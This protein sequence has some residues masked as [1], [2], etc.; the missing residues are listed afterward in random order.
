MSEY[1][2]EKAKDRL[3]NRIRRDKRNIRKNHVRKVFRYA[4]VVFLFLGLG[5]G[6]YN[7][8]VQE[9][10]VDRIGSYKNAI[11]LKLSDG[12]LKFI[13]EEKSTSIVNKSGYRIGLQ[14]GNQLIY[15][16]ASTTKDLAYN[17]LS[18]PYGK[19]FILVLADGTKAHLNSGTSLKYP[20][21]FK[22]GKNREVFLQGEG[23]FD[24]AKDPAHPFVINTDALN[25]KVLGTKFN[26]SAY[27]DDEKINTVLVE[28]SV[29]LFE[30]DEQL[31]V[32]DHRLLEPGQMASWQKQGKKITIEE[33]D[34]EIYTGWMDGKIIFNHMPFR[35]I[36]K[37]LE[38]NYNVSISNDYK[39]LEKILF[40]ASFD[41]ETIGQVLLAFSRNYPMRYTIEEN[42]IHI[43]KP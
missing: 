27:P 16:R 29:G 23:Y 6:Y 25:I 41:T 22:Y 19:Q 11:A 17:T 37:K 12:T 9:K 14:K 33:T 42:T 28:G 5:Y 21:Q 26:V 2:S 24:V 10:G 36:L 30:N 34:T 3:L 1:D 13:S 20:V 32:S 40:T 38:R 31:N 39:E 43:E 18:D 7:I 35:D 8:T 15:H 4:A